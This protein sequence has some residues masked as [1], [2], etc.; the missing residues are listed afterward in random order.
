M[1][2]VSVGEENVEDSGP[3][4][5]TITGLIGLAGTHKG[6]LAIHIPHPV[7][8]AITSNFLGMDISEINADVLL[9]AT[10]VDGVYTADPMMDPK[11]RRYERLSYLDALKGRLNVMDA[12]AFS[13]CMENEIPIIVFD[14]FKRG[15]IQRAILGK[16][17]GTLVR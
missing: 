13:L 8:M 7:A 17:I 2:D 6:V 4:H 1:M 3:L 15:N 16:P 14:L 12:A 5:E 9:K 11:A 10:K